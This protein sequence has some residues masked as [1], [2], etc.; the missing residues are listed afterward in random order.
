MKRREFLQI[1]GVSGLGLMI[2]CTGGGEQVKIAN[3]EDIELS[4]FVYIDTNGEVSILNHKPELGQ[5]VYQAIPMIIAE[6]LEVDINSIK[7]VQAVA[8]REKYGNQGIGGS[9][10]VRRGYTDLRK[11]GATGKLLL[12][13][14]AANKWECPVSECYAE[15]GSV[16]RKGTK[17]KLSYGELVKAAG[18]LEVPENEC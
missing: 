15:L 13:Q 16:L 11:V 3:A 1:A 2:G 7:I 10:S 8:D 18:M 9:T 6:E 17:D 14:A 12:I 5:G 4:H